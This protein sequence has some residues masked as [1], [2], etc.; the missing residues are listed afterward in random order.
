MTITRPALRY[1]GGKFRL[2]SWILQFFPAHKAYV[3]PYV[4]A[5]NKVTEAE[6]NGEVAKIQAMVDANAVTWDVI[7]V[8]TATAVQGCA[9]GALETID[10]A[11]LGLDR[12]KF[13][14]ASPRSTPTHY[15]NSIT[16]TRSNCS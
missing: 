5:G 14:G 3:E 16:A 6:Y 12:S 13:I 10:W 9:Q 2:A 7:D 15:V 4:A 8:D 1:H 11:K